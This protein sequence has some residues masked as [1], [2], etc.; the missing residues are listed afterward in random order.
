MTIANSPVRLTA[1][2]PGPVSVPPTGW[3]DA[4][5]LDQVE[6]LPVGGVG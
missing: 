1:M 5:G 3:D 6:R 4:R 2:Q